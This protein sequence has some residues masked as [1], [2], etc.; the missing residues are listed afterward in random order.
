M[1]D[2]EGDHISFLVTGSARLD[3]YRK[4]GGSL[5]GRYHCYRLHPFTLGELQ[6]SASPAD[7]QALLQFGGFPEPLLAGYA[8]FWRRWQRE[9]IARVVYDDLRDLES[10]REAALVELLVEALPDRVGSP[11]S[12]RSLSEDLEVAHATVMKWISWCYRTTSLLLPWSARPVRGPRA[13]QSTILGVEPKSKT[14]TR[15]IWVQGII[16][17]IEPAFCRFRDFARSW[18]C[19]SASLLE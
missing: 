8:R 6:A 9:R 15:C 3:H 7:V 17:R 4:D 1:Y 14:S 10:V 16:Y 2:T 12:V 13:L 11:L 19:P 18:V 5:Q